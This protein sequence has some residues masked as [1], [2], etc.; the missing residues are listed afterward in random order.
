MTRKRIKRNN[1]FLK[2][3]SLSL[4]LKKPIDSL[5]GEN[6]AMKLTKA[7]EMEMIFMKTIA[8]PPGWEILCCVRQSH[9]ILSCYPEHNFLRINVGSCKDFEIDQVIKVT[10]KHF[11][12]KKMS[13]NVIKNRS[14]EKELEDMKYGAGDLITD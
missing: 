2:E 3:I 6:F 11:K 4:I 9:I 1:F 14:M 7:I 12:P 8:L 5:A 13:V 10:K